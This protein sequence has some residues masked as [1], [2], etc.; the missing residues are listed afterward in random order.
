MAMEYRR[1]I[2][3]LR[4]VAV[5]A[6]VLCHA[7]VPG[8]AG[9]FVGVD[10]FF[11]ISGYLICGILA[12]ELEA[13]EFSLAGFYERRV[14]R[15]LPP[16]FLVI[17][18]CFALGWFLLPPPAYLDLARS[19]IPAALF[20][21]NLHFRNE[22]S[23]YFA[24]DAEFQPLL[25]TWSLAVEEQFYI[26]VPLAMW[27]VWTIGRRAALPAAVLATAA[28][29]AWSVHMV[30]TTPT[31][32][33][34]LLQSR[35]W[36]LGV[37]AVLA[38]G[39]ARIALP[40]WLAEAVG[41]LGIFA[42]AYAT[43]RY[44]GTTPFPGA[45]A[46]APVLG[47]AAIIWA[48]QHHATLTSRLLS[49]G[50]MVWVGL[51]SYA[52]YLWHWPALVLVRHLY[53]SVEIPVP[54]TV[55][56]L[57]ASLLLA[58]L[59]THWVEHPMRR[60]GKRAVIG[61]N[62]AFVL[63]GLAALAIAGIASLVVRSEGAWSRAPDARAV[64]EAATTRSALEE[65]C[66]ASWR[67]AGAPCE[68]GTSGREPQVFLWGDSHAASLLPGLD[69]LLKKNGVA[70]AAAVSTGCPPLPGYRRAKHGEDMDCAAMNAAA[71]RLLEERPDAY[72]TVILG[73]RWI[74][75]I[76]QANAPGESG[77]YDP[78][79]SVQTGEPV[80]PDRA[81]AVV[82]EALGTLA[83]QITATGRSVIIVAG[84]PEQGSDVPGRYLAS[85]FGGLTGLEPVPLSA[86]TAREAPAQAILRRLDQRPGV[87]VVNPL[88][89]MCDA[90]CP[91]EQ[92]GILLYRDGNHLT[93]FASRS[94]VPEMLGKQ[95]I[96]PLYQ[97]DERVN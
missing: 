43:Y 82:E 75:H 38:L 27:L 33:F 11:V 12:R 89:A 28:S 93:V 48:G 62:A 91:A 52:L 3:G 85:R 94:L 9:G 36:E 55:L 21:S 68:F 42:I 32:A 25:H 39:V 16:L 58:W 47:A 19:A 66:R 45:A 54:A 23:D 18:A 76:A 26:A 71:V 77:S 7:G 14:R 10:V 13:G 92:G 53:V 8:F 67:E 73:A 5:L 17:A 90:N 2:D 95:L 65:Q 88:I 46:L 24:I 70:G 29:F 49:L 44:D 40:R 41:V 61:R 81:A 22:G 31:G 74:T 96:S 59:S 64:I 57:A 87:T 86:A 34:Y 37:G 84:I 83:G 60:R 35:A 4:A 6:V 30:D 1:D 51:V 72:R 69:D 80:S 79:V 50:P 20:W 56:A 63:G 97:H 15:I 78:L